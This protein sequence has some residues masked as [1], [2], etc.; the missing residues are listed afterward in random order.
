MKIHLK[1]LFSFIAGK[2]ACLCLLVWI[3]GM[4][5]HS[6]AADS[7]LPDIPQIDW[8]DLTQGRLI[9]RGGFGDVYEGQWKGQDVAIKKLH[10]HT[11]S[12]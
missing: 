8:R 1:P 12:T 4:A 9:G 6:L 11:L 7:I 5:G 10:M 3:F 2:I